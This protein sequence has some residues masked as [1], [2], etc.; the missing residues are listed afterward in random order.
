MTTILLSIKPKFVKE[1]LAGNKL[2]E[3]RKQ[4][5]A[6]KVDKIIIYSS[7]PVCEVVGEAEIEKV[8][9]DTP[10]NIWNMTKYQ[11]GIDSEFFFIYFK[12]KRVAYA[13]KL[14]NIKKYVLPRKLSDYGLKTAPQSFSY[15][16]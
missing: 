10:E 16:K 12:G 2:F 5:P 6:Q 9:I 7:S 15:I 4:I 13:Y 3:F 1:I 8:L 11:S 14:K